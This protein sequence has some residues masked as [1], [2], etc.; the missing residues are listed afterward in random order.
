VVETAPGCAGRLFGGYY[1]NLDRTEARGLELAATARP[2]EALTLSLAYTYTWAENV[3]EGDGNRGKRLPRRPEH[4]AYLD[5]DYR[6][7][8]GLTAGAGVQHVGERFDD[9]ANAVRLN[10]YTLVDARAFYPVREG[11]ELFGRVENLFDAEYEDVRLYGTP[12]RG[13]FV[14]VRAAF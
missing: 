5:A 7:A 11:V 14:G 12:G 9:A 3:G 13:A 2:T 4:T 6:F 1:A 10:G 8:G